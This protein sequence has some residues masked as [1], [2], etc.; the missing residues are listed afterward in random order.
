MKI[1][2]SKTDTKAIIKD[3]GLILDDKSSFALIESSM[4]CEDDCINIV[5][6]EYNPT[7]I[8]ELINKSGYYKTQKNHLVGKKD[9]DLELVSI[10]DVVYIEGINNDTYAHTKD[11]EY[12]L[13]DKLYELEA[14]L[15]DKLFVRVSKSYIVSI[16]HIKKIKPTFNGKLLLIIE[17]NIQL[18]VSRHYISDFRKILGM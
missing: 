7:K 10:N 3:L 12:L 4:Q 13:K 11:S 16:N 9:Q 15:Q 17:S 8:K 5:F 6:S 1:I 18:E 2:R 14:K